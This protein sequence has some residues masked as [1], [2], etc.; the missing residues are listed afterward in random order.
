MYRPPSVS[1]PSLL[2]CGSYGIA[3]PEALQE[4]PP[5]RS[6]DEYEQVQVAGTSVYP[7]Q[8][9]DRSSTVARFSLPGTN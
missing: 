2:A 8:P 9:T 5:I 3:E 1:L 7:L 4:L 6:S